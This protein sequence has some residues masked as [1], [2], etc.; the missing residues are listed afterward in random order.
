MP[1]IDTDQLKPASEDVQAAYQAWHEAGQYQHRVEKS[2]PYD[3]EGIRRA[4]AAK[5]RAEYSYDQKNRALSGLVARVI[6][7]AERKAGAEG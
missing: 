7:Q 6:A 5:N 3:A 4:E 2:R 1:M